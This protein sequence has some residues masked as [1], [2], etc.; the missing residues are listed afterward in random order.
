MF[1]FLPNKD[2]LFSLV[3]FLSTQQA[4]LL[5]TIFYSNYQASNCEQLR[6]SKLIRPGP[7]H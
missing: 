4:D 6:S 2:R 3:S 5:H 7:G 1:I